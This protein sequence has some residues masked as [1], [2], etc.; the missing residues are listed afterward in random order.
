MK[1][2][3]IQRAITPKVGNPELRFWCSAHCLFMFNVC[4]KFHVNMSSC[5][6]VMERTRKYVNTQRVITPKEGKPELRF[7]CSA[8]RLM[9]FN[10]CVKFRENIS[11]S[12]KVM[13]R[14]QKMLTFKGQ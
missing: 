2:V 12:F 8:R 14:T 5:F 1:I 11:S 6:K 7:M 3:N 9:A 13:E 10:I 4:V